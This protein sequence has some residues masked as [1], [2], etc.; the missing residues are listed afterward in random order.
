MNLSELKREMAVLEQALKPKLA[1]AKA[2]HSECVA[3]FKTLRE[4]SIQKAKFRDNQPM[5]IW[6]DGEGKLMP[7]VIGMYQWLYVQNGN[8]LWEIKDKYKV[9]PVP[10]IS[11]VADDRLYR[12]PVP[13]LTPNNWQDLYPPANGHIGGGWCFGHNILKF[14]NF[15]GKPE[16]VV[17]EL[18]RVP[19]IVTILSIA[20]LP[21]SSKE[22]WPSIAADCTTIYR[23]NKLR[24][25]RTLKP[26]GRF[27]DVSTAIRVLDT[28]KRQHG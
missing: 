4:N 28:R 18:A 2:I 5:F 17:E 25:Y 11:V 7:Y 1:K 22:P 8:Q 13:N 21:D 16:K 6:T 9:G 14:G 24:E 26:A 19:S 20:R 12:Y 10:F 3:K 27:L 15:I 23:T